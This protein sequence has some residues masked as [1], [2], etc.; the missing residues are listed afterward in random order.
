MDKI[1]GGIEPGRCPGG[2]L[3]YLESPLI[4]AELASQESIERVVG[5]FLQAAIHENVN[6]LSLLLVLQPKPKNNRLRMYTTSIFR[7]KS[8]LP[9]GGVQWKGS[10]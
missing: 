1:H 3:S 4:A 5:F 2:L 8:V 9:V 6:N 7:S 10:W